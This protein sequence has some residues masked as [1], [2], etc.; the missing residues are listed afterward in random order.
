MKNTSLLCR[1]L[2]VLTLSLPWFIRSAPPSWSLVCP[3]DILVECAP[4]E[5]ISVKFD[6]P[7]VVGADP[8][9]VTVVCEPASGSVFPV[10]D[11]VVTCT[12]FDLKQEMTSCQ[13]V[14]RVR[15]VPPLQLACPPKLDVECDSSAGSVVQYALPAVTGGCVDPA[16]VTVVCDPPPGSVFPPGLTTVNCT[17]ETPDGQRA[18]CSFTVT[19]RDSHPPQLNCP[20]DLVAECDSGAGALVNFNVAAADACDPKPT[21]TCEPPSGSVFPMGA[22]L[23]TCRAKDAAGNESTCTFTVTVRDSTPPVLTCPKDIVT[24]CDTPKGAVVDFAVSA[25]D[26]CDSKPAVVCTP[27]SGSVFPPGTTRVSCVAKDSAG[28]E[29]TCTFS[30]TVNC[31]PVVPPQVAALR[32]LELSSTEKLQLRFD[33]GLP[34]FVSMKVPFSSQRPADSLIQ[35]LGFLT[36]YKELYRLPVPARQLF[37][38]QRQRT[39]AG[40]SLFF[41]QVHLGRPVFGAEL[42]IHNDGQANLL[43]SLGH[44]VTDLPAEAEPTI[45]EAEARIRAVAAVPAHMPEVFGEPQLLWFNEGLSTGQESPTRLAWRVNV[46]GQPHNGTPDGAWAVFV[47]ALDGAVLWQLPLMQNERAYFTVRSMNNV[48]RM[49]NCDQLDTVTEW[50][51]E[52]G[53]QPGYPGAAADAFLDGQ[54]TATFA[55][56]TWS[57]FWDNFR[58][59]GWN[60]SPGQNVYL[61][62]VGGTVGSTNR[63]NNACLCGP[64]GWMSF[65]EG[66]GTADVVAH[67]FTHGLI[68]F[69]GRGG[70]NYVDESGALNEHFAD[71]FAA[72]VD[73]DWLL[74]EDMPLAIAP[75]RPLRDMTNPA[76]RGQPDHML[77]AQSS[78]FLGLRVRPTLQPPSDANDS[79]WVHVNSGIPN[80]VAHLLVEGGTHKGVVVRAIGRAKTQRL[81]YFTLMSSLTSNSRLVDFRDACVRAAELFRS[82]DA[83]EFSSADVCSVRNAFASVG[84][85]VGDADCDGQPDNTDTDDDND[86]IPDARDNC[87]AYANPDQRD[88]DG[89]GI[90]DPCDDDLDNDGV[91]NSVDNCPLAANADRRDTDGDGRGDACDDDDRDGVLDARDNCVGTYNPRQED[92][93]RDGQGDACDADDDN[94]GIPD[95]AD[96]CPLVA[97]PSQNDRDGD[98]AGDI[99]D[100]CFNTVNRDQR[101]TDR[102]G[103]GDACDT[104]DDGDSVPDGIDN[105]PLVA[106][107]D[108]IDPDENGIGFVCDRAEQQRFENQVNGISYRLRA[109]T[110]NQIWRVPLPVCLSCPLDRGD[111]VQ[112]LRVTLPAGVQFHVQDDQGYVLA[113]PLADGRISFPVPP[114]ARYRFPTLPGLAA[115]ADAGGEEEFFEGHRYYLVVTAGAD[116]VPGTEIPLTLVVGEAPAL[117]LEQVAGMLFLHWPASAE[118]YRLETATLVTGADGWKAVELPP[119]RVGDEFRVALTFDAD[120][121]FFRLNK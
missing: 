91:R 64:C 45:S 14:V 116:T 84:L 72:M 40:E 4:P 85:G 39:E 17:A 30:V 13:F 66:F 90:G 62:H 12:G 68:A 36:D 69:N 92:A 65:G 28:N 102:D 38:K 23:V 18:T 75:N 110:A 35:S 94:D 76:R 87:R 109:A 10:G 26:A 11:T 33:G 105:C 73:P 2:F 6:A 63:W 52:G 34:A 99:C 32:Q 9:T 55:D 50:F 19:V 74:G 112:R 80:K 61:V 37:L 121:R 51:Q 81:W 24:T 103:L 58:R 117:R 97:N 83:F 29:S 78:D 120:T 95:A 104:D 79:G 7:T 111:V 8:E 106:N 114:A 22:T 5:G 42:G 77:A 57:Y 43:T 67:E 20:P 60:N 56:R 108:Q 21:I 82:A 31:A 101:D 48:T 25:T 98:G 59:D 1:L 107:P 113:R 119:Q 89:D 54:T 86:Y 41:G 118:G 115:R 16:T 47:D 96:N 88:G 53:V 27:V 93:D 70:L 71:F 49:V 15:T 44:W 3:A 100:N 46:M